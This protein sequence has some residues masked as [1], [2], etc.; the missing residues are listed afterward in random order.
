MTQPKCNVGHTSILKY[1]I[2]LFKNNIYET[3]GYFRPIKYFVFANRN[4]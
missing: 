3:K 2:L 4:V 1:I